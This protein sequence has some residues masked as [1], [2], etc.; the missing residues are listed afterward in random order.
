MTHDKLRANNSHLVLP[1]KAWD[2]I[3][4]LIL[5]SP[6]WFLAGNITDGDELVK[7]LTGAGLYAAAAYGKKI[8]GPKPKSETPCG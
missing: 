5:V 7:S 8:T 1:D 2:T 6:F 3:K 4:L